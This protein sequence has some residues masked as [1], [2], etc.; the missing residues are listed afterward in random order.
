MEVV[1]ITEGKQTKEDCWTVEVKP[2]ER[3]KRG[4]F[5]PKLS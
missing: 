1:L 4:Q 3:N 2:W 5:K